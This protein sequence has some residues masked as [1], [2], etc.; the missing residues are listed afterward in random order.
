[1]VVLL[2]NRILREKFGAEARETVMEK[3]DYYR[4]MEKMEKIY[5]NLI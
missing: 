2:R 1:M 5:Q 4:E 3:N